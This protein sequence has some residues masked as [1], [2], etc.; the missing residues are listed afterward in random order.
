LEI[1]RRRVYDIGSHEI[2]YLG[3]SVGSMDYIRR[4]F[5]HVLNKS[6]PVYF[7]SFL[8]RVL[9]WEWGR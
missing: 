3:D 6:Y 8:L 7:A 5:P 2:S 4:S 1:E 9:G